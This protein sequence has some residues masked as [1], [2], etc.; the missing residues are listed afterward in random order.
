[1]SDDSVWRRYRRHGEVI[2]EKRRHAWTW[3]TSTGEVMHAQAGDWA[4]TDDAGVERS[5]AAGMFDATHVRVGAQRYRR[6][7]TTL[8]RRATEQELVATLEG[9]AVAHEG[10][11]IVQGPRGEQWPVPDDQFRK[12]YEGPIN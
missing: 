6:Y 7:G 1:M 9:H 11:W 8:A 12:T 10:D 2:A 4:V 5:V 3:T